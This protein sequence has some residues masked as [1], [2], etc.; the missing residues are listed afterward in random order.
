VVFPELAA[1]TWCAETWTFP[2]PVA[3]LGLTRASRIRPNRS[4]S[5][6]PSTTCRVKWDMTCITEVT[7]HGFS[8][9]CP[10]QQ[11][12]AKQLPFHPVRPKMLNC[13]KS[14]GVFYTLQHLDPIWMHGFC[15]SR[16]HGM[17]GPTIYSKPQLEQSG[18]SWTTTC[19]GWERRG[20]T[21]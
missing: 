17:C 9:H 14:T 5:Q 11:P 4:Q 3:R 21:A 1:A 2:G 7:D 19:G 10:H 18:L 16:N 15:Q 12:E 8:S 13:Y 20:S 6:G